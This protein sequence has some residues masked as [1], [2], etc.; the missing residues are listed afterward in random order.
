MTFFFQMNPIG[1]ILKIVLAIPS[2]IAVGRCFSLTVQNTL[3]K[4]LA[5]VIKR[6]SHGSGAW[7]KAFCSESMCFC[8]KNIHI[9]NII[10][11]FLSLH[12]SAIRGRQIDVVMVYLN[13]LILTKFIKYG[14]FN[15]FWTVKE[16]H[17]PTAMIMLRSARKI[18]NITPIGFVWKKKDIYT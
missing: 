18:F 17:P 13:W 15:V 6:A 1:V 12:L 16:K 3:N 7:M 5:S 4:A 11:T 8:K 2:V 10:N 9:S 14:L